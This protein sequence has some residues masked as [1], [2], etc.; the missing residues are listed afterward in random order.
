MNTIE[1]WASQRCKHIGAE[2]RWSEVAI[3]ETLSQFAGWRF[4][5]NQLKK[6]FTFDNFDQV[7]PSI[8]AVMAIARQQ[9]HHPDVSFG[10]KNV[11]IA[12]STHSAGGISDN[13]W[14]CAAQVEHALK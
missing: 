5:S 4:E 6:D 9:D 10:F 2:S 14:I 13:D 7:E 1:Q 3:S 11:S 12:F 8:S